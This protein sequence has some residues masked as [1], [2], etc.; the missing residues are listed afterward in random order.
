MFKDVVG[1]LANQT[2]SI[3]SIFH[4]FILLI[5]YVLSFAMPTALLAAT[6]LV[7]G[8]ISADNELTASRAS[9]I[10]FFELIMPIF[11]TA[12]ALS[13]VSLYVNCFLA[14]KLKY[15]FN[16]AF[17]EI[18]LRKPIALLEEG[19]YIRDFPD[20]VIFIG[21]RDIKNNELYNLRVTTMSGNEMTQEIYAEK[22][23]L[24]IDPK[25]LKLNIVLYNAHINQRD[26]SDPG[27]IQKRKWDVTVAEYPVELDMTKMIDE[28]RAV[29]DDNH[30]TSLELWRQVLELKREG[31]LATPKLVEI[32]KRVALSMA[33]FAFVMIGLP[34]GIQVQRKE[35]SIGILIS[36]L[37]FITYYLLILLADGFKYRV[38]VYPEFIVWLPNLLFQFIGLFLLWRQSKI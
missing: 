37:L 7:V 18:A 27:N 4:F 31:L 35:T 33:C 14:P 17:I 9:G 24:K 19:Q 36:L 25:Q 3:G 26:P 11:F 6:L 20:M 34:L 30:Y 21:K 13:F 29:K 15:Q 12:A 16:Q 32:H 38:H 10:S 22:G 23:S 28:R 1:L 2:V 5:P 8:R